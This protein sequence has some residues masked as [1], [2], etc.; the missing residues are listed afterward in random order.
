[1][2]FLFFEF[3]QPTNEILILLSPKLQKRNEL[4]R[5]REKKSRLFVVWLGAI[6]C[7]APNS[8]YSFVR[9]DLRRSDCAHSMQNEKKG[10]PDMEHKFRLHPNRIDFGGIGRSSGNGA[11]F[12]ASWPRG[13]KWAP[14][15]E[16][17]CVCD[18]VRTTS[19]SINLS[20]GVFFAC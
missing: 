16:N 6:C 11:S 8:L 13:R 3:F 2:A 4:V 9:I 10:L 14:S 15:C 18:R 12:G 1:M 20:F 7:G 5:E 17:L 19:S